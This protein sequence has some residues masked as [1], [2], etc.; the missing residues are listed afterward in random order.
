VHVDELAEDGH[1]D[2]H[3]REL[4]HHHPTSATLHPEGGASTDHDRAAF[5][6]PEPSYSGHWHAQQP[7]Q[8]VV[9]AGIATLATPFCVVALQAEGRADFPEVPR[10]ATRARAPPASPVG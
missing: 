9:A 1:D 4:H 7:F 3:A 6:E 2:D 8:R 5:E 10:L